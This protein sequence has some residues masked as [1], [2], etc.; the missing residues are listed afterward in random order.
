MRTHVR[1]SRFVLAL[2]ALLS[3]SA[4][5]AVAQ[6]SQP[7][8]SVLRLFPGDWLGLSPLP[9]VKCSYEY[10]EWF[11]YGTGSYTSTWNSY[12]QH[13]HQWL[14]RFHCVR[15]MV[16]PRRCPH[17]PPAVGAGLRRVHPA[18]NDPACITASSPLTLCASATTRTPPTAVGCITARGPSAFTRGRSP[19]CPY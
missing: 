17:L 7:H 18:R 3:L 16:S 14:W 15:P 19:Q 9:A 10:L 6:A 8:V 11:I 4:G 13:E 5:P 1:L 2:C 12:P